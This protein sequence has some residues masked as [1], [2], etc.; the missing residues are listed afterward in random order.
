MNPANRSNNMKQAALRCG[1]ALMVLSSACA[2][3]AQ[4]REVADSTSTAS[5]QNKVS[6]RR[7]LPQYQMKEVTGVVYDAA[8]RTPLPG[9]RVQSLGNKLYSALTDEKG[10]YKISVPEHVTSLYIS[11]DGY[12]AVQVGLR[13][14]VSADAYL[15]DSKFASL[16]HD[17]TTIL[18]KAKFTPNESSSISPETDIENN[19]NA[20]VRTIS[21]GGLPAQG[22]A[23]FVNGINSLNANA[24]PLVVVDG[25]IWDMQYGRT[26]LHD[27]FYN[28]IF[29]LIDPEDVESVEVLR[30]GTAIYGAQGAN[31]VLKITT[32]RGHSQATRINIRAFGGVELSPERTSMMNAGQYRNYLA[33]F[34]GTTTR[35]DQLASSMVIPFLNE[36]PGYLYYKQFH[37]DTDWA[38]DLY[39]T[40]V[41]QNYRVGVQGGDDVAMYNLSLGYTNAQATAK[42][43][44]FDRLNIRFNTDVNLFQGFTTELD[45]AYVRN[46]YNLRDNGW[47][48]SYADRNISSPNVLGLAQSPFVD[49]YAYY[50]RYLGDN[51]LGLV[52]NNR[53]YTG[54]NYTESN[55][56]LTFASQ[57]G[58]PGLANPYWILENGEGN[59]KNNQEQTQFLLNVSPKYK[60]NDYWTVSNRFA[61]TLNRS[62]EKYYMPRNG[63]PSKSVKGLG[64]VQSV[65]ASQFG[66]ETT[67]FND[68]RVDWKRNF[69]KHDFNAYGGFRFASYSYS[70]SYSRGYNNDNDKM[71]DIRYSLQY[72][73]EGGVNDRW[74]NLSYYANVDYNYMNRYFLKLSGSA[75]SS[76]RFGREADGG[77]K[78]AGVKWGLFPS[79]QAGWVLTNEDWFKVGAINYAKLTAGFEITGN[80]DVDYYATRTYFH[81]VKF[82]ERATALQ[83][84]NIQNPKIKW[85]TTN[86]FNVA[87]ALNMFQ[88]RLA[89]GAE[90]YYAKT[91]DLLTRRTVSDISGL[92]RQWTN[93][94]SLTNRGANVSVNAVLVNTSAL[95]WQLGFSVGHYKNKIESLPLTANNRL[96]TWALDA[97][98]NKVASSHK[99]ISG[100]T[101]SVYGQDN[102]LTAVGD[103]AG[104][105]YG[106][107]TAGVFSTSAEA[108]AAGLKY[109]TGLASQPSRDFQAGDMHFV[110][111]NGDGWINEAD[112]VKIGDP[113]PDLYG[114]IFTS[115]SWKRLTLDVNLKYSLGNDI[116]N[117]QRMQLE[118]ANSITNQ[119]TA[120]VNRWKYEGQKTDVP[121][122][123]SAESTRW[124]NNE[125]FSD[126]WI[127]DGSY[128]KLKKV[129]LTYAVPLSLSWLQGLSVWGEANNVVTL[130]KYWGS[131]PEVTAGNGVLYQGIDAGYLM[132]NRNFN[133]GVTINL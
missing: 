17:G 63:T 117:Y 106:Y 133:V 8:T 19:L 84:A 82:L 31:G 32:K 131:D 22:A 38:K 62:N 80:D 48:E 20:A 30:N 94:G 65:A 99:V 9:V 125:R 87:L 35:A 10:A 81:N 25:V 64:N 128:L 115:L 101:S 55:N 75:T 57:F 47:A 3:Q 118:S 34:L 7:Q 112:R 119:T 73:G 52:H 116:Y 1:V 18:N 122:T 74:I 92:E 33:E 5:A 26:T 44:D 15:Y 14:G 97:N 79:V 111:Q 120:V 96:E 56:P 12:N 58:Y 124:V 60:I 41:T 130:T 36:D 83:L 27:G 50:V 71:P 113:N 129:R 43:N 68:F 127:E 45:M 66:K 67:L 53:V 123:M 40:A 91:N 78:I 86:R 23:M 28:N 4:A 51:R 76:S 121:R 61:Y 6:S 90:V 13:T 70:D 102:I 21:R 16:Y 2:L 107:K 93:E 37:N 39:R 126:R 59:N 42:N 98:G 132:L 69:G 54:M 46:A 110:D 100:Y 89:L 29:N 77:V 11:T 95:K 105:F 88:N 109:P 114:N 72:I 24:Q 49:P 85:E 108:Q 104:V 103:A